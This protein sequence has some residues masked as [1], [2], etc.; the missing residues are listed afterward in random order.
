MRRRWVYALTTVLVVALARATRA[1]DP[2]AASNS[3]WVPRFLQFRKKEPLKPASPKPAE[4]KKV[5]AM[6]VLTPAQEKAEWLRRIAVCDRL[7]TIATQTNDDD[8]A[9]KADMLD[10]RSWDIYR[11]RTAQLA[12]GAGFDQQ[13]LGRHL[14]ADM[15]LPLRGGD[16]SSAGR[17]LSRSTSREDQP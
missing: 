17:A 3:S 9:R 11:Q 14:G 16:T 10:Q 12:A 13:A 15:R 5:P 6:L 8:L 1:E 4:I 7:R 2:P